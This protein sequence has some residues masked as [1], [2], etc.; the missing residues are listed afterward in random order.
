MTVSRM[1]DL[2]ALSRAALL[3]SCAALL[4]SAA[5]GAAAEAARGARESAA[6]DAAVKPGILLLAHGGKEQW[7]EEVQRVARAADAYAPT[8][9]AFG[10]ADRDEIQGAIDRLEARGATAIT[11]VPLFVSSHSS[12]ITSTRY[13]L[14]LTDTAPPELAR[15]A[16]MRHGAGGHHGRGAHDAHGAAEAPDPARMRP[17]D[18]SLPIRMTPALDRHPLVAEILLSRA[19]AISTTPSKEAVI[20]VA[21]GP[22]S[23]EEN[24]KWMADM[25]ALAGPLRDAGFAR[26]VALT[27]RDDAPEPIWSQARAALRAAV[28]SASADGL[29]VLIVP[30]LLSFGGIEQ[31]IRKRLEGLDYRMA[32][33][34]LLPD[35]RMLDWVLQSAGLGPRASARR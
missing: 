22:V 31:G 10:M 20:L 27:V 21:H 1:T 32:G 17:V 2:R 16:R 34:A 25:E 18:T 5:G 26:V 28:E 35:D 30:H 12:V 33:Q 11:A 9:V 8:E 29:D 6:P 7:N 24:Q 15:Y 3:C 14:G 23:D 13:L 4:L 19:R